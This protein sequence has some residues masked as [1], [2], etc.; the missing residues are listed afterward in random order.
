VFEVIPAVDLLG[1]QCVRLKQGR[2]DTET[3]Y[4]TDPVKVALRWE[5]AGAKRLHVVDLDGA[6][7]GTPANLGLIKEIIKAVAI[8]VQVGGGMR[9]QLVVSDLIKFGADRVILGTTAIK[10]PNMLTAFCEKYGDSVAV[11]IDAKGGFAAA[12]GWMY[13]TK[14]DIITFAK[15]AIEL[16]VKRFIY[17]DISRDG[18]LEGP[19]FAGIE[20]FISA[21]KVPVIASGGVATKEDIIKLMQLKIE[22]CVVGKAL[23]EGT[24]KLEEIV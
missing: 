21:I 20:K 23:Y 7:T 16:G 22:G 18:M 1:G 5:R 2:Y 8:P 11:A 13:V 3:V 4:E 12:E 9:N 14:K 10:N 15:E 17:T 19:N 6:R 24:I